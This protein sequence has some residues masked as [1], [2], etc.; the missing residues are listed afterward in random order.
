MTENISILGAGNWGTTL[1]VILA[2]QGNRVKLWEFRPEAASRIQSERENREFLPGIGLPETVEVL[3]DLPRALDGCR[4][5][6]LAMPS[7]VLRGVCRQAGP[8][9]A[10][11]T[12]LASAIKGLEQ[13]TCLRMSQ[14]ISEEL[15]HKARRLAVL[16]G[17]NIAAE[18][19]RGLPATTVAASGNQEDALEL[20]SVLMSPQLRV[21]T[22]QDVTGVE[23]GGA[24]KNVI[25]IA[26]GIADGL[27]LGSNAK[28]ALLTRGLA[29]IS[30]LGAA[31]GADP[32]TFAGLS[33]MGD[34]VTTCTSPN[35]RN[36][37]VG[38]RIGQGQK[39]ERILQEMVMVAE[40]VN[41]TQAAHGLAKS[42]GIE[43]PITEQMHQVLFEGK[44]ARRALSD[45]MTRSP[46]AEQ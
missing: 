19:A 1:A 15:K 18:I 23:L 38:I 40:G 41:T 31:L 30:R 28:G 20:Q 13:G 27:E 12:L 26:A 29:E 14:V 22:S 8:L 9:L 16:S 45:L 10:E 24:L 11:G 32:S 3:S 4:V 2:K 39:L 42:R 34:L 25:A 37:T 7:S 21:Y 35:S 36:H 46:R 17:P 44:D 33:G 5:C 6:F 43:M